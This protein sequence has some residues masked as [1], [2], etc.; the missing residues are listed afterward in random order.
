MFL[1]N[2]QSPNTVVLKPGEQ[3]VAKDNS[4]FTINHSPDIDKVMAWKNGLFNFNEATLQEVMHQLER[5]YDIEVQYETGIPKL[6]FVG[7]MGR[8]LSLNNVLRGLELSKVHC[9]LEGRK[10]IVLP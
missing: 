5:W 9:R 10:L 3:V 2:R 6:E 7:K 1:G 4:P 8:D